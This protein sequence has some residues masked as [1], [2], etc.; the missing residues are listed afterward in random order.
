M[1]GRFSHGSTVRAKKWAVIARGEM[2][3]EEKNK[4]ACMTSLEWR[5]D[6]FPSEFCEF[7]V[8]KDR[9]RVN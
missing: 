5:M 3:L 7:R 8:E 2:S 1:R 6:D 9:C 4:R